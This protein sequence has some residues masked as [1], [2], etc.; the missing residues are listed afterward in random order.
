MARSTE[1]IA[2]AKK[3][4]R[5]RRQGMS[6]VASVKIIIQPHESKRRQKE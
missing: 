3:R 2:A 5:R 4:R 6:K 1:E